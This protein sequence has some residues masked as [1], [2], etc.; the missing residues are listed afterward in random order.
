MYEPNNVEGV[1]E[2][3]QG[4][5]KTVDGLPMKFWLNR[6]S[7]TNQTYAYS[8]CPLTISATIAHVR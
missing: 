8:S 3:S 5:A 6:T 2:I 7:A 1:I 4:L